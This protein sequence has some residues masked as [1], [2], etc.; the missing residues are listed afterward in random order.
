MLR[1]ATLEL[2]TRGSATLAPGPARLR[3]KPQGG[4][5]QRG[6]ERIAFC[7]LRFPHSCSSAALQGLSCEARRSRPRHRTTSEH[8]TTVA[9]V[10]DR[11]VVDVLSR[12]LEREKHPASSS[13]S[14]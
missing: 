3:R 12:K 5:T 14:D 1:L 4:R 6:R 7:L 9:P 8:S 13:A 2:V 11:K 10:S